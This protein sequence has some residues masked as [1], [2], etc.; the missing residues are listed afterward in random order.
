MSVF[1]YSVVNLMPLARA[2]ANSSSRPF[3]LKVVLPALRVA[4]RSLL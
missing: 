1:W 4:T 2:A 3:S